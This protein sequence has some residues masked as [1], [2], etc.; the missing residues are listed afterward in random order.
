VR[1]V[2]EAEGGVVCGAEFLFFMGDIC[3]EDSRRVPLLLT[4]GLP[5]D[6]TGTVGVFAGKDPRTLRG[7]DDGIPFAFGFA[8]LM[9]SSFMKFLRA[10]IS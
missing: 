1:T 6:F 9:S 5:L 3:G 8:V 4:I 10:D 7:E 2:T